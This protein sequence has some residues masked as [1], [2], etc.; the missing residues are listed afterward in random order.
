MKKI[1][2]MQIINSLDIGGAERVAVNIAAHLNPDRFDSSLLTLERPGPFAAI[3]EKKG[4]PFTSLHKK[5][6][7]RPGV[8]LN[9][10]RHI[11]KNRID[12][13]T[14]H[15]YGALFYGS[16][17]ARLGGCSRLLH[18]DHNP[19]LSSKRRYPIPHK[20][21]SSMAFKVIAVSGEVRA[22]LIA[23]E[24]IA[25]ERIDIIA[26]G[27]DDSLF[28]IPFDRHSLLVRLGI[29]ENRVVVGTGA[30]LVY[31]KGLVHLLDAAGLI[32]K[33]RDDFVL[34]IVGDGPLM[35]DLQ[36]R[37]HDSGLNDRVVFTG[38]RTDFHEIIRLFD[39]FVLPSVSEGLPLSL[40]EAMAAARAIVASQVGGIPEVITHGQ[41]GLLVPPGSP[42]HL[43]GAV[44]LLMDDPGYRAQ[45]GQQARLRFAEKHSA[46][47]MAASYARLYESVLG[48]DRGQ[49]STYDKN[50][51]WG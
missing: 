26:N 30:R 24:G 23:Q 14:T 33:K 13:V 36:K 51:S 1:R 27:V 2:V 5:P 38:A 46:Q 21:L 45:C 18:V 47:A 31:E 17:G 48:S 28:N 6:G 10:A 22:K 11:R 43:A 32:K 44:E 25:P 3:L 37:A 20:R 15:N 12:I 8:F 29:P 39:I 19:K 34:V 41:T 16:F 7:T 35:G 50:Q 49:V 40:L 42:A 9:I 4:I